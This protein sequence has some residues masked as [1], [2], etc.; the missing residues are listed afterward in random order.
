VTLLAVLGVLFS[1]LVTTAL[2]ST[3]LGLEWTVALLFGA[4]IAS[5]D[6][7]AVVS[8]FRSTVITLCA[9]SID[10]QACRSSVTAGLSRQLPTG[11]CFGSCS[12]Q[13]HWIDSTID[14]KRDDT[15]LH[16]DHLLPTLVR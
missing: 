8:L 6:P 13:N 15:L 10:A 16:V 5:T 2:V 3:L 4:L 1:T 14:L 7:I 11:S 12:C 9:G